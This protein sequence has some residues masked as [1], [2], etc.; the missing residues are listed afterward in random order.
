MLAYV[1]VCLCVIPIDQIIKYERR[2]GKLDWHCWKKS[3]IPTSWFRVFENGNMCWISRSRICGIFNQNVSFIDFDESSWVNQFCEDG[4]FV[5]VRCSAWTRRTGESIEIIFIIW[6][7]LF[8]SLFQDRHTNSVGLGSPH[9]GWRHVCLFFFL[10]KTGKWHGS[11]L[12]WMSASA[13]SNHVKEP[14]N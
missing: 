12:L 1:C 5:Q 4:K 7:A 8:S 10:N 2:I 9:S 6:S 3:R 14:Q 11:S 13:Q